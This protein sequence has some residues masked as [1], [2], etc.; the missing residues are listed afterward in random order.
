MHNTAFKELDVDAVYTLFPMKAELLEMFFADLKDQS[1]P[2]FGLNVTVPHKEAVIP[3]L[4]SLDSFAQKAGAVNTVVIDDKRCLKGFNTDGPGFLTHLTEEGFD[5]AGQ[6]V[7]ILGAGGAARAIIAVF[8]IM[9]PRPKSVRLYDVD[10]Q[11]A[12]ALVK[13]LGGRLDIG[14]VEVVRTIDDLDI[15]H[16]DL[17]IN[18]TP[19]GMKD[20]DPVLVSEELLH[21]GLM[22]YDLVYNPGETRL[23]KLAR[24]KGARAVNGLR[25]LFYQGVLAFQ[26]WAGVELGEPVKK[27]MWNELYKACY[28]GT[29][30]NP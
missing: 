28:K 7:A 15:Q 6:R 17:L 12:E 4:D 30:G 24:S 8:A 1:S 10:R 22:V 25:M 19:V 18:A 27:K 29:E 23:L 5:P 9:Q 13:D 3:F 26:H 14:L 2:I 20:T 21:P 16:A 11:K